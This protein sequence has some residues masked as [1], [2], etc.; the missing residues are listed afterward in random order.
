MDRPDGRLLYQPQLLWADSMTTLQGTGYVIEHQN[1]YFGVTSLHF[2]N[3]DAGGLRSATWLDV[4]SERPLA[5]FR[6]SLGRPVRTT[7]T[8]MRHIADD[9]LLLPLSKPPEGGYVLHLEVVDRYEVG[10]RLWFPN[11]S[12]ETEL[13]HVWMDAAIAEDAGT[14]LIVRIREPLTMESQSGSPL[15]NASTGKVVGMIYGGEIENGHTLLTLC[16]ARSI[17]KHLNRRQQVTPLST[18]IRRR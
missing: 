4:A 6:T 1:K 17:V 13:G 8:L 16:P 7:I 5:T 12:R 2:M 11:K 15:L 9:F 14:H 3:F 10:T 18:S